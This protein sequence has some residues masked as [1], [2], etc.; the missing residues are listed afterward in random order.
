MEIILL[1][2]RT[3]DPHIQEIGKEL[4]ILGEQYEI[5]DAFSES[6]FINI[7]INKDFISNS[8]QINKKII[9]GDQIKSIWNAS[10]IKIPINHNLAKESHQFIKNE[11]EEGISSLWNSISG[12]CINHPNHIILTQN[13][14]HQLQKANSIGLK[15]PKTLITNSPEKALEFFNNCNG[16]MIAK[17][18]HGSSGLPNNNK[19]F[20][21]NITKN[22]IKNFSELKYSPCMFQEYV[23]KKI[24]L[25]ITIIGNNI[26]VCEIHSQKS[27]K[28]KHDWRQYD[29]FEHT[30]YVASKVSK[31][32]SVKLLKLMK[33]FNLE[34][35]TIDLIQTP[36]DEFVFLEINPNGKWLWIQKLTGMNIARDIA[37]ALSS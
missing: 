35:S 30:P 17:T 25:R 19:I 22:D 1:I 8:F 24:E 4:S 29:D 6:D 27:D 33:I 23:P 26:H 34:F 36:S 15:I 13:R 5:I 18:L 28:T 37:S 21:T 2:G 14:L 11:W 7:E 10:F 32:I 3:N 16:K 31:D 12:K 9:K 20:S